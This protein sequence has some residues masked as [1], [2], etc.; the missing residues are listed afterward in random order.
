MHGRF[1]L[2]AAVAGGGRER[3]G[4]LL[5]VHTSPALLR[6]RREREE[7]QATD[8]TSHQTMRARLALSSEGPATG[9]FFESTLRAEL[10][11]VPKRD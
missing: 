1:I 2:S 10:V 6:S 5:R 9:D 11:T 3:L 8:R 7:R 4:D